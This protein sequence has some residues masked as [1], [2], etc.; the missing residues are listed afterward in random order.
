M[1]QSWIA[2]DTSEDAARVQGEVFRRMA[3][4]KRLELAF[5]MT[6]DLRRRLADGIRQR[7]P[8]YNERQVHLA[9]IRLTLGEELFRIVYPG[10]DVKG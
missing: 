10:V 2:A 8:A 4:E 7:H 5:Q 1:S 3:P 9:V 6:A